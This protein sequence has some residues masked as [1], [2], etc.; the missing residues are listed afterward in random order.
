MKVEITR[1]YRP[2]MNSLVTEAKF[3]LE[4]ERGKTGA[5]VD[6]D[7]RPYCPRCFNP[8]EFCLCPERS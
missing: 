2:D 7:G 3:D 6:R 1:T 4:L 8:M 5:L